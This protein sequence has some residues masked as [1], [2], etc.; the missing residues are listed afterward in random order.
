MIW[1]YLLLLIPTNLGSDTFA[2][3]RSSYAITISSHTKGNL[4][5]HANKVGICNTYLLNPTH[6]AYWLPWAGLTAPGVASARA[7]HCL[8]TPRST[9]PTVT[10]PS[11]CPGW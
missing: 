9:I 5:V 7:E 11:S 6:H 1:A 3:A 2:A 10:F 8:S 4:P